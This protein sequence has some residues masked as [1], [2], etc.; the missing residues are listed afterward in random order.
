MIRAGTGALD[1]EP[2]E[3]AVALLTDPFSDAI[4]LASPWT[5][6]AHVP[7]GLVAWRRENIII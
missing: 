4:W 6:M 3:A 5:I 7:T 2:L 1:R